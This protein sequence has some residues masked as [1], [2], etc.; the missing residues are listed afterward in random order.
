MRPNAAHPRLTVPPLL[1]TKEVRGASEERALKRCAVDRIYG[2]PEE[3]ERTFAA[4]SAS[5]N[6]APYSLTLQ[7]AV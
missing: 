3:D 6:V 5:G 2:W 1:W 7:S 4:A